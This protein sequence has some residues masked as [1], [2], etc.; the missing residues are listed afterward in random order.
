[1]NKINLIVQLEMMSNQTN[2][3]IKLVLDRKFS[4]Q[5]L[6]TINCFNSFYCT[7]HSYQ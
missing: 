5:H 4:G 7:M 3:K 6:F 2:K 1:M